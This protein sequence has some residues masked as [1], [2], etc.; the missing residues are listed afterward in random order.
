MRIKFNMPNI[1]FKRNYFYIIYDTPLIKESSKEYDHNILLV[2]YLESDIFIVLNCFKFF[3]TGIWETMK[4]NIKAL[5]CI[6]YNDV[7]QVLSMSEIDYHQSYIKLIMAS[8]ITSPNNSIFYEL[9]KPSYYTFIQDGYIPSPYNQVLL[10]A[11]IGRSF[12]FILQWS[13]STKEK[14]K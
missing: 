1:T 13:G 3:S 10:C 12:P 5:D 7:N 9:L 4:L 6:F 11:K 8:E 2:K 14:V